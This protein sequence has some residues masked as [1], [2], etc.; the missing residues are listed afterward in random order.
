MVYF[1]DGDSLSYRKFTLEERQVPALSQQ[2]RIL[3][4]HR[5]VADLQVVLAS[6]NVLNQGSQNLVKLPPNL[7][8]KGKLNLKNVTVMGHSFGGATSLIACYLEKRF[9]KCLALDPWMEAVP[10][11]LSTSFSSLNASVVCI[12]TE[13]FQTESSLKK[14]ADILNQSQRSGY[15]AAHWKLK[16][17]S[18]E[19]QADYALFLPKYLQRVLNMNISTMPP[20][21]VHELDNQIAL[22]FLKDPQS[23]SFFMENESLSRHVQAL[24]L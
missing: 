7:D 17:A 16:G 4:A 3:Q 19:A 10:N 13:G 11:E 14:V 12:H 9:G 20:Q 5:R 6:L 24:P 23:L 15:F 22:R 18:H 8:L 1:K 21:L 2:I